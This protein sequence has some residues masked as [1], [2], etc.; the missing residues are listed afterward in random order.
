MKPCAIIKKFTHDWTLEDY[1]E[2]LN[3]FVF[4]FPGEKERP[5]KAK[6]FFGIYKQQQALCIPTKDLFIANQGTP[7]QF[8]SCNSGAPTERTPCRAKRGPDT[9]VCGE[10]FEGN[11]S[12]VFEVAFCCGVNL[13]DL[14]HTK[15]FRPFLDYE[16]IAWN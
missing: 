14:P 15:V 9:F 5:I 16:D 7:P 6:G 12:D 13:P 8:S 4:F 11:P 2:Y 10:K 1:I 3:G